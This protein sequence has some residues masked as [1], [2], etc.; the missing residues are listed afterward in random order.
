MKIIAYLFLILLL[1]PHIAAS[2]SE[3][4]SLAAFPPYSIPQTPPAI[5]GPLW[6]LPAQFQSLTAQ[7]QIFWTKAMTVLHSVAAKS[8]FHDEQGLDL[9]KNMNGPFNSDHSITH[10]RVHIY[11]P[12]CPL[13]PI[14]GN[15]THGLGLCLVHP[16]FYLHGSSATGGARWLIIVT[17][18]ACMTVYISITIAAT[19]LYYLVILESPSMPTR[20]SLLQRLKYQSKVP[21]DTLTADLADR[22][23][24]LA[25]L[26]SSPEINL[27]DFAQGI[28][29]SDDAHAHLARA[30]QQSKRGRST[31]AGSDQQMQQQI[32]EVEAENATFTQ[33][34]VEKSVSTLHVFDLNRQV[35]QLEAQR[36]SL[37][38]RVQSL[39]SDR[40]EVVEVT[41]SRSR[42]SA[43]VASPLVIATNGA[44]SSMSA[45]QS[46]N[47]VRHIEAE[48]VIRDANIAQL[49]SSG[50]ASGDV[51]ESKV[52]LAMAEV[53]ARG[54]V[55]ELLD[56]REEERELSDSPLVA[57]TTT[58]PTTTQAH[59]VSSALLAFES[60]LAKPSTDLDRVDRERKE[61]V[62]MLELA[63]RQAEK[64]ATEKHQLESEIEAM[65]KLLGQDRTAGMKLEE[66]LQQL[67]HAH[68][69]LE[70][71]NQSDRENHDTTVEVLGRKLEDEERERKELEARLQD[72]NDRL[73]SARPPSLEQ[74]GFEVE[75]DELFE[76]RYTLKEAQQHIKA[77]EINM[78]VMHAVNPDRDPGN[79]PASQRGDGNTT[80]SWDSDLGQRLE[81]EQSKRN[82]LAHQTWAIL[83]RRYDDLP[84]DSVERDRLERSS[85]LEMENNHENLTLEQHFRKETDKML[86][87]AREQ[88]AEYRQPWF[89][90]EEKKG[91]M[92]A[93]LIDERHQ[94]FVKSPKKIGQESTQTFEMNEWF[95]KYGNVLLA[96]LAN[97]QCILANTELRT[98]QLVEE[99]RFHEDARRDY[100]LRLTEA[101]MMRRCAENE[102]LDLKESIEGGKKILE[103]PPNAETS[104]P[105]SRN[106]TDR[107]T[108][109]LGEAR[110]EIQSM[111]STLEARSREITSLSTQLATAHIASLQA[112]NLTAEKFRNDSEI[113]RLKERTRI[114]EEETQQHKIRMRNLESLL[115][116]VILKFDNLSLACERERGAKVVADQKCEEFHIALKKAQEDNECLQ[117]HVEDVH[118]SDSKLRTLLSEHEQIKTD[119][120]GSIATVLNSTA[121]QLDDLKEEIL[122]KQQNSHEQAYELAMWQAKAFALEVTVREFD[123]LSLESKARATECQELQHMVAQLKLK[124][125]VA[126]TELLEAETQLAD[127][128][129]KSDA[130]QEK[131]HE[132]TQ[133]G[134]DNEATEM[135]SNAPVMQSHI[136]GETSQ[137]YDLTHMKRIE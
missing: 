93:E 103:A 20:S 40:T 17:D 76:A 30:Q 95:D 117:K 97:L 28:K 25:L 54:A 105:A 102:L 94:L 132:T 115:V 113:N 27:E 11:N 79:L 135:V 64:S 29:D 58:S 57:S 43:V 125:E 3:A 84:K 130:L 33:I 52:P 14:M 32:V 22:T 100:Q 123:V 7:V 6:T 118:I 70:R 60:Q 126:T 62:G 26:H 50:M 18:L 36:N 34:V 67:R 77:L 71:K 75:L 137:S 121:S 134:K 112:E 10:Q 122:R 82:T 31:S 80:P 136:C 2:K 46:E 59:R 106:E 129:S 101:E 99:I 133:L 69:T 98:E 128:R 61:L 85:D 4:E 111:A 44:C 38:A 51:E 1:S 109:E 42:N 48:L 5:Q 45:Q 66:E 41:R 81:E 68:T 83:Q 56:F 13:H 37:R 124:I 65:Q 120:S 8:V 89:D 104:L 15:T 96:D 35:E 88:R 63:Q 72:A 78:A 108:D 39:E 116:A 49:R 131:L 86:I 23:S 114:A 119:L 19:S 91:V 92:I 53:A 74:N 55:R 110:V 127:E 90:T 87:D 16:D 24:Q 9:H 47:L 21:I 12:I 107:L 73:E